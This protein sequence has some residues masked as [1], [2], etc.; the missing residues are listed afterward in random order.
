MV[1]QVEQA[2]LNIVNKMVTVGGEIIYK[3]VG[4]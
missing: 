2:D 3:N 1:H 4:S